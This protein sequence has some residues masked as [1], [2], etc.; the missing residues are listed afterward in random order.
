MSGKPTVWTPERQVWLIG[1]VRDHILRAGRVDW[2]RIAHSGSVTVHGARMQYQDL[3]RK[4]RA[5]LLSVLLKEAV[6]GKLDG[7]GTTAPAAEPE[8]KVETKTTESGV[9]STA[10]G[11]HIKTVEDLLRH[12]KADMTRYEVDR[13]EAT[14]W[15]AHSKNPE[16]K[17]V[18]T[19]L[20]RV[21]VRLKPKAGPSTQEVVGTIIDAAFVARRPMVRRAALPRA[22]DD[23]LAV[24]VAPEPHVGKGANNSTTGHGDYGIATAC[25][26]FR[27][28]ASDLLQKSSHIIPARRLIGILGDYF[29]AD[30][31]GGT[32]TKGTPVG[33][34]GSAQE[35][36]RE[37]ALAL[38]DVIDASAE[39]APTEVL[40]TPGNHDGILTWA[41][42]QILTSHYRNDRRVTVDQGFTSRKYRQ[43]GKTLL[44][45]THGDKPA[46]KQLPQL[47]SLECREWWADAIC[48]EI[49][50]GHEHATAKIE[51]LD[52][53]IVRTCASTSATDQWHYENGFVGAPR[54]M[55]AWFYHRRGWLDCMMSSSP[56]LQ[57]RAA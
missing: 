34:A 42:Q 5:P 12:V 50:T 17:A 54:T 56:T 46:K 1:A 27:D 15:D 57:E 10:I 28:A 37:G 38:F 43:W 40:L 11:Q 21:W 23:L 7:R 31:M 52:G 49:H 51:T 35:M 33:I 29:H 9:E 14:K 2:K 6:D 36:I 20:H 32:T 16:G 45:F 8:Q 26:L 47:M 39:T 13:F 48:K 53:V 44:G 30:S 18:V 41:L 25:G 19:E 22:N 55:E 3:N 24:M 4:G